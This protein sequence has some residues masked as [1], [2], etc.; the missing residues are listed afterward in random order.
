MSTKDEGGISLGALFIG[1]SFLKYH[2]IAFKAQ[3]TVLHLGRG[4]R[5][6]EGAL[7]AFDMQ[8]M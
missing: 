1:L 5:I 8:N 6:G 2:G 4:M 3:K 7:K